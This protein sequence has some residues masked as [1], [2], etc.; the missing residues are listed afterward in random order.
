MFKPNFRIKPQ[1]T[2]ALMQIEARARSAHIDWAR[3]SIS[4]TLDGSSSPPPRAGQR[5]LEAPRSSRPRLSHGE[6]PEDRG[7]TVSVMHV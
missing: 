7:E 2:S 6:N 5:E 1:I 4:F 3:G